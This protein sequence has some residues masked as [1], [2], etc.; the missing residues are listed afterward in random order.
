MRK[1]PVTITHHVHVYAVV[2]IKLAVTAADHFD[3]MKRADSIMT[4]S[5][6]PLRLVPGGPQVLDAEPADEIS[7]YLVDETGDPQ[8]ERSR[9]YGCDHKPC[10]VAQP[11]S[12]PAQGEGEGEGRSVG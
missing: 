11:G 2:R 6:Y 8:F 9:F 12:S 4:E 10:D 1:P 3:A 7:G 5:S